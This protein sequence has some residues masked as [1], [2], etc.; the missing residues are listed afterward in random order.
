MAPRPSDAIL[1][2]S[3]AEGLSPLASLLLEGARAAAGLD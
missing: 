3:V 1:V 2:R